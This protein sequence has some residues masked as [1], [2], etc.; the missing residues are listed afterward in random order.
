[1]NPK[2][3]NRHQARKVGLA[4]GG[5]GV[6]GFTHV[7]VLKAL[8]QNG[9]PIDLI[10]GSSA[11]A[12]FGGA[13]ACGDSPQVIKSKMEAYICSPEFQSS[14]IKSFGLTIVDQAPK[15][16][17]KRIRY[18][19]KNRY[20]MVKA[21]FRPAVLPT[22]DF[23]SLINYFIPD[24]DIQET[25]IP[26]RAVTTD[27][28]TGKAVVFSQGP[29]RQAVLASCAFPGAIEPIRQGEWILA[30]GGIA[31][32][33]PVHAAKEAGADII[34]AVSVNRDISNNCNLNTA[35]DVIYRAGSIAAD[36]LMELE[37][38]DADVVIRP[39]IGDIHWMDFLQLGDLIRIGEDATSEAMDAIHK[40]L[41]LPGR[42]ASL[43]DRIRSF[44]EVIRSYLHINK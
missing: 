23:R 18:L 29:M 10:V 41:Y 20:C 14:M 36:M 17:I 6:R 33:V 21:L 15:G 37:L 9:I 28:I 43:K 32:M 25:P 24:I 35:Q 12:L 31:S 42:I 26:F 3:V 11:G 44:K 30:D 38:Q 39:Q 7:G 5:G 34:I 8:E 4:L 13:Y 2:T 22:E 16:P 19:I 40:A 1:M 27:L